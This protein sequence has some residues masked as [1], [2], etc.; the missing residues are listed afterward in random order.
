LIFSHESNGHHFKALPD[1][2]SVPV[3]LMTARHAS[4][5][6]NQGPILQSSISA[7][8]FTDKFS[9]SHFVQIS[10]LKQYIRIYLSTLGDNL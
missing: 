1:F 3:D 8:N 10:I 5:E 2:D 7:V 9:F 4:A 6:A